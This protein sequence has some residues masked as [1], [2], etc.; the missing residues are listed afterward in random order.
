MA[1]INAPTQ[2]VHLAPQDRLLSVR[3]GFITLLTAIAMSG[4]SDGLVG[5]TTAAT[6]VPDSASLS[7][8]QLIFRVLPTLAALGLLITTRQAKRHSIIKELTKFP[9]LPLVFAIL[10]SLAGAVLYRRSLFAYWKSVEYSL[11]VLFGAHLAVLPRH[12]AEQTLRLILRF[13]TTFITVTLLVAIAL[14]GRVLAPSGLPGVPQISSILPILGP[15]AIG[16]LAVT[17]LFGIS[18]GTIPVEGTRRKLR[19][20]V[21]LFSAATCLF[22]S[23][24]RSTFIALIVIAIILTLSSARIRGGSSRIGQTAIT[25]VGLIALLVAVPN[26]FVRG[27]LERLS[28]LSNRT[29]RWDAAIELILLRPIFGSGIGVSA[30]FTADAAGRLGRSFGQVHN[31]YLELASGAGA[32]AGVAVAIAMLLMMYRSYQLLHQTESRYGALAAR[33]VWFFAFA[34]ISNS[35][36]MTFSPTFLVLV[37]AFGLVNNLIATQGTNDAAV[38]TDQVAS[39]ATHTEPTAI[40]T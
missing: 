32:I 34:G 5:T 19:R 37:V 29:L 11:P 31:A 25:L 30:R 8:S 4:W 18:T 35:F 27:D 6:G 40:D 38:G 36:V 26:L 15:G 33:V 10:I 24:S 23:Q 2:R 3:W 12:V 20:G 9:W 13:A 17:V 39:P 1:V 16:T 22:L 7:I 28:T 14:P 21:V